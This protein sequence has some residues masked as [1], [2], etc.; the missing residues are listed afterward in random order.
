MDCES[1]ITVFISSCG[2]VLHIK[3]FWPIA[4]SCVTAVKVL[5]P[6]SIELHKNIG[7]LETGCVS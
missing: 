1:F 3:R 5:L 7:C 2:Y 6:F 4:I